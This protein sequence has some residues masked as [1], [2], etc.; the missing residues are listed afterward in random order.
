MKRFSVLCLL[1]TLCAGSPATSRADV[2][3]AILPKGLLRHI[4][5]VE[6]YAAQ[7]KDNRG[8][9]YRLDSR[10]AEGDYETSYFYYDTQNRLVCSTITSDLDTK[11]SLFYDEN[12][13][14][15]RFDGW[16][17]LGL[18]WMHVYYIEYTYDANGNRLTRTNYNNFSQNGE[19][20]WNL[21]GIYEYAYNE[22]NQ[23]VS[24]EMYFGS[25]DFLYE[26]CDY[27]YDADGRPAEQ[28]FKNRDFD[29]NMANS[30]KIEYSYDAAGRLNQVKNYYYED[31]GWTLNSIREYVFDEA[32][33]CS[34]MNTKDKNGDYVDRHLY[35]F[36]PDIPCSQVLLPTDHPELGVIE[37]YAGDSHPRTIDH[38]YSMDMDQGTLAHIFDYNYNY[39]DMTGI[40]DH[41]GGPDFRAYP[42]P[43][44]GLV[45]FDAAAFLSP[46]KEVAVYDMQGRP[47]DIRPYIQGTNAVNLDGLRPGLYILR[48]ECADGS[49]RF[50]KV[51]KS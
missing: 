30:A 32:G 44:A 4:A 10:I 16:Q 1:L 46:V 34:E 6:H 28:I 8:L 29:G 12:G 7:A 25:A 45:H 37:F 26:T 35:E 23:V 31:G 24:H 39:T 15:A 17:N 43:A 5:T 19:P 13:N 50:G 11:D 48:V 9:R 33:N 40:E 36:N 22:N 2:P 14:V 38:W 18:E 51:V 21:G 3:P 49:T 27:T 20:E 41:A 42:N 47:A